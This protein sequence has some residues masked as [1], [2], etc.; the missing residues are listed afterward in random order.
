[1]RT[2]LFVTLLLGGLAATNPD[3][4]D[5][6]HFVRH[7]L[8]QPAHGHAHLDELR[9]RRLPSEFGQHR[10]EQTFADG[11]FMHGRSLL[12]RL[13]DRPVAP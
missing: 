6:Q 9:I 8:A 12:R 1:M 2:A 5:Y 13:S 10:L 3:L 11:Q 4:D 7:H